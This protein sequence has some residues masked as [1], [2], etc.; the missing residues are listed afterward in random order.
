[1]DTGFSDHE[2]IKSSISFSYNFEKGPGVWKNNV[3]YYKEESFL[4]EFQLFWTDCINL[5][6]DYTRNVVKW[7]LDFKYKYKMFYIKYCRQK[8]MMQNRH[9]QVLDGGLFNAVQALNQNPDSSV[10]INNYNRM[11]KEVVDNKIKHIKAKLFK[12]E[13]Q[14]LMQGEKPVK[15]FF[16]RFKNKR[17]RKPILSLKGSNGEEVFDIEG[18]LDIAHDYYKGLFSP[19]EVRQS[20]INLFLNN[21]RP[22]STCD[23]LM[24]RLMEPFSLEEIWDAI[25]SFLNNRSPGPDGISVEFY[26]AIF[27]I[28]KH[29]LRR[30]LNTLL[31]RGRIPAKFKAGLITLVPKMDPLNEIENFRPISL[32]NTDYKIFT[33][34]LTARMNPILEKIIHGSQF[35]QPGR[36]IQEMNTVIRDIVTD[37][38]RSSIDSFFVSVDFRKA[39][40]SV[41]HEFLLKV[42]GQYG[43]PVDFVNI[44]KELF[45]DAGSHL[46]INGYKSKKIKLKSGIR[47][48]C[49]MST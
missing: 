46:F 18:I 40:D 39:Y 13:A 49:P 23:G 30:V 26:K 14:H 44:V 31:S 1:M 35:A 2:L 43:F 11:K 28:I 41:N 19:R 38:D 29:D 32:L 21:I 24:R 3:K 17:E 27:D 16:D 47:Q 42:L 12:S 33:K 20:I 6:F 37:M 25:V 48:G 36:D 45:R 15:S 7:W 5:G 8:I 34:I 4:E 10:L 9:D 22:D